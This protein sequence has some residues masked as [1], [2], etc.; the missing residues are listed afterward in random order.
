M[1]QDLEPKEPVVQIPE[2]MSVEDFNQRTFLAAQQPS[3]QI[4]FSSARGDELVIDTEPTSNLGKV[5]VELD[6]QLSRNRGHTALLG[7][8]IIDK[9][10][11]R[12]FRLVEY[13]YVINDSVAATMRY[14]VKPRVH[15]TETGIP[16]V[17]DLLVTSLRLD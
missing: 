16:E 3:G 8:P 15:D 12:G 4:L 5:R 10:D 6:A 17:E 9:P 13:T 11:E 14:R 7:E 2:F 1:I